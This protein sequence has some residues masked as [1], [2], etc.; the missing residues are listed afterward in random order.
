MGDPAL[1][2]TLLLSMVLN[3]ALNGPAA[4]GMPWLAEIRFHAGPTGLGLLSAAWAVGALAGTL[5]AGNLRVRRAGLALLGSVLVA[6]VA[7]MVV[8]V[9]PWMPVVAIALAVMGIAIGYV[10]ILAIS[11]LQARVPTDM[12]GRVM[13]LAMLMGFGITPLSL[14]LAGALIDLDATALF[15]GA[16]AL[17][18]LVGIAALL[19]RYP[20]AFDAPPPAMPARSG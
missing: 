18:V 13:A 12:V 10:N 6:G 9:A 3:F 2:T 20:A 17:V 8:G 15:L 16:G 11:W 7:M 1:R 19:V 5:V 4:V 14:G